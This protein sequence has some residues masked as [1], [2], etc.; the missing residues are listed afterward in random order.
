MP[1]YSRYPAHPIIINYTCGNDEVKKKQT[2][3]IS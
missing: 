2:G 1:N 3:E